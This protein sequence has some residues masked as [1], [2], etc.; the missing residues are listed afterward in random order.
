MSTVVVNSGQRNPGC[1]VQI[2]WFIFIGWWLGAI[3]ITLAWL[4]M[5]TVIGIPV[6]VKMLNRL[7]QIIAQRRQGPELSIT[8]VDG[9]TVVSSGSA[10]PQHN[11]FLRIIYFLLIGWWFSGLWMSL[12]YLLCLT[13]IGMP[14]GFWM[15]DRTPAIVSLHRS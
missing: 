11:I 15:F 7:P 12:A 9:V 4:L 1:L 3:W 8:T 5:L 13:I 10:V 14:L 6:A 2:L